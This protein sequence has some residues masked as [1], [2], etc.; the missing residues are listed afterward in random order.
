MKNFRKICMAFAIISFLSISGLSAQKYYQP[1]WESMKSYQ[2]PDWF[3]DAKFGI[4]IHWGVY[5]VP[6]FG[7]EW[8]PRNMYD[9][10]TDEFKHHVEKFGPQKK[11]GY[12]DFIT[13]FKAEKFDA[14]KW[15]ELFKKAG[16]KYIVPVAEHH[17]GFAMYKT[18]MTKWN[19]AEMG[20]KRDIIG[21]L[22]VA[23]KKAGLVFGLSS[24]RIEHWWFFNEGRK[25]DSDVNDLAFSDFYGPAHEENETMSPEFMNDWLLRNTELVNKY[26]PQLFWFDWWIEQPA[27]D[28]YRKSF[29]A[30][31]YNKGLEW[32]KGVVINYKNNISYPEDVAVLDMERGKLDSIRKLAWQTDDAIGNESWG[33]TTT[34]TFKSAQYVITNLIDIVSKNGN[35]LLNIGP[36]PDGTITDQETEVLTKTGEWLSINGEAIYGT[37]P[38]VIFG[39]GPTKSAS[40][41][42]ADQTI[43]FT[44]QDV[45]FTK[46]GNI[47]YATLLG[48]PKSA[49]SIKALAKRAK[50]GQI[51]KIE[52]IGSSEKVNWIQKDDELVIKP[53]IK[54][55]STFAISYRIQFKP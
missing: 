8:Y 27:L 52:L 16:A 14:T 9:Q 28:P 1:N 31:Y 47:V 36:R 34:N 13:D 55:P 19:A 7:S 20:P 10:G 26:E 44:A 43:P 17:D 48:A 49:T 46:K 54:Y 39:E 33:Y 15:V 21:E 4:F 35:L 3:R 22:S 42:F 23:V 29:A 2:I 12:K 51:A 45:R 40:G 11:F 30:Y 25:F 5:S 32:N 18:S 41:S 50:N 6:S 37:R 24:H 53:L 38:W